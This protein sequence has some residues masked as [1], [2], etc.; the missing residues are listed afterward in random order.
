MLFNSFSFVFLFLPM[1]VFVYFLIAK[2]SLTVSHMWLLVASFSFYAYAGWRYAVLLILSLIINYFFIV[3]IRKNHVKIELGKLFLVFGVIINIVLLV[4]LKY[5]NFFAESINS[6]LRTSIPLSSL[7]LPLGISFF[8]FSQISY[9]IDTYRHETDDESFLDY[10]LYI[11]YFP[12]I[13]SGPIT[14][15]EQLVPQFNDKSKSRFSGDNTAN[16]LIIFTIGLLKKLIIAD[17]FGTVVDYCFNDVSACTAAELWIVMFSY[18]FQIYFDF[19]GYTD[20]AIGVSKIL[21]IDLPVNF[22]SPYQA[23]SIK[24]FWKRWHITLTKFLTKYIYIPLGGNRK[25]IV[26]TYVNV[27]IVFM[28]S[29]LW[30]GANYTFLLWGCL[31]GVLSVLYKIFQKQY[32][33]LHAAFR[34]AMNFVI[35]SFLWLLFRCDSVGQWIHMVFKMVKL[36]NISIGSWVFEKFILPETRLFYKITGLNYLNSKIQG[37]SLLLMFFMSFWIVMNCRNTNERNYHKNTFTLVLTSIGLVL[38]II[39]MG[40]TSTFVYYS[41]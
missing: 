5:Y 15:H 25:G 41:F 21:N 39:T 1:T 37:F 22:D 4:C 36:E 17:T 38:S 7:I 40:K 29:G 28:V 24:E 18:S 31:H 20:M 34:W 26:R 16:G 27:L 11:S 19:S 30:H 10:A 33:S 2:R 6:R 8:T 35:V 13:L 9:L 12:K 32:D 23:L 14:L 3:L